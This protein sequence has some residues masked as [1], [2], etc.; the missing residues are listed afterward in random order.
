MSG[1]FLYP[2]QHCRNKSGMGYIVGMDYIIIAKEEFMDGL[3][4]KRK[5]P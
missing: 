3:K 1:F 2:F 4:D 5:I